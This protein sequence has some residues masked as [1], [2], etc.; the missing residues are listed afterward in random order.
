M[1]A[2]DAAL[3]EVDDLTYRYRRA[4]EPAIR[5]ISLGVAPGEVLLVAGPSG[6]GKSTLIRAINGLI[7]HAY[8]GELSGTVRLAGQSTADLKLREIAR[9]VGTVLQDPAKQIVGATVEAELAFGPENLGVPRGE[10]RERIRRTAGQAGIEA[11]LGRE[12]AALS[13]GER[14]LLAIAGILMMEPRLYVVDEPLANLDPASAARLLA[15]LRALADAGH[16]IVIVEH[17]VEEALELRP[18]RVLYLDNGTTRYYGA[19]DGFL[20]I[21]DPAAVK[22]PFEVVLRRAR[23]ASGPSIGPGRPGEAGS[24]PP[25]AAPPAAVPLDGGGAPSPRDSEVARLEFRAVHAAIAD[26]KIL[27]GVDARLGPAEI[28]AVLGPNGSGK[29][30]LFRTAMRLLDVSGGAVLVDGQPTLDRTTAQLALE[31]GYVFQ[32]PSQMLFARTVEEEL[33]F[34]PRNLG[35]DPAEFDALVADC[36]QRSSLDELE[37][38]RSRPPLALSFGQQKRLA[39]AI[40]LALRPATLILDEPSAG[41]DHQ[42]AW[43]FMR[44]VL[45][46]P[47]LTSLYFVTHDVD[48]A[49]THADRILLFRDGRIVADGPPKEVI[50]DEARWRDC[51]LTLTSLMRANAQWGARDGRFLDAETLARQIVEGGSSLPHE[52]EGGAVVDAG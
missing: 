12:T 41:Q 2:V 10:I 43:R 37:E 33:L 46:I 8:P 32:S 17:R 49:L 4:T 35:R 28:V 27:H 38:I 42:T 11:L 29:T 24:E 50:L 36:L 52:L 45:A 9:T 3:V 34:G 1:A 23:A 14:Q 20:E 6:C 13:G 44:E 39:L 22:L 51:N 26:H 16:A 25:A 21:A 18:D 19:V 5:N 7:P 40:A 31:F 15:I 48:L 30:T 47:G